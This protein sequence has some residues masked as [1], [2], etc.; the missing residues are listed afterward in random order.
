MNLS[1]KQT[2]IKS[3]HTSHITHLLQVLYPFLICL[4]DLVVQLRV[5][6]FKNRWVS[7]HNFYGKDK[8]RVSGA[9][10]RGNNITTS[11]PEH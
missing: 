5:V 1:F 11:L 3:D 10:L 7:G 6:S 2:K 8:L 4:L 9:H